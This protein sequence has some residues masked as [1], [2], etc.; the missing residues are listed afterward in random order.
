MTEAWGQQVIVE[1]RPGANG[2]VACEL[3]ARSTPDGYTLV[4]GTSGTHGINASLFTKLAYD[5][6]KD[7][8]PIARV[9]YAPY[10]L[11]SH[12]SLPVRNVKDLIALANARP[13]QIAWAAGGSVSQLAADLF[14][15]MAKINVIIVPYKGNGPAVAATIAGETSLIFGGIA[16]ANPQVKAGRLRGLAVSGATRSSALPDVPT[17][18]EAGVPGYETVAWGGVMG[19]AGLPKEITS[20]LLAEIRKAIASPI[21]VERYKALDTEIDASTPEEFLAL[22]RRETPK[23]AAVIRRANVKVD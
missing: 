23:W 19:P 2:A 1:S 12:P 13:G 16:Q 21:Y 10:Y 5:P 6:V 15:S 17:V 9:G 4:M 8:A 14:K 11:V 7:F 20:R 18:A 3:V 22:V